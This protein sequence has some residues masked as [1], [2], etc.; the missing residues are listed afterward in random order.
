MDDFQRRFPDWRENPYVLTM[1][2]KF[3]FLIRL[4]TAKRRKALR[5][6]MQANNL[7]KGK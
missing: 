3:R 4:I 6:V 7:V 5:L 2:R 1:N